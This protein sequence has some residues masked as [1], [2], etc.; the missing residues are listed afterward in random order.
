MPLPDESCFFI[1]LKDGVPLNLKQ[2]ISGYMVI[3]ELLIDTTFDPPQFSSD[4]TFK[5]AGKA[6]SVYCYSS[7][8][9]LCLKPSSSK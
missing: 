6:K 3:K 5:G 8:S 7:S 2:N 9:A 1:N 4:Y